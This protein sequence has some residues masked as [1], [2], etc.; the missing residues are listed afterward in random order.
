[1][2]C[3]ELYYQGKCISDIANLFKIKTYTLRAM[4]KKVNTKFRP[5]RR[6]RQEPQLIEYPRLNLHGEPCRM[7]TEKDFAKDIKTKYF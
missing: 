7:L 5:T 4:L 6:G 3:Q 2:H 1:M